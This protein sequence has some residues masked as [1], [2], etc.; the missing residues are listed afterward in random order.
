MPIVDLK[1]TVEAWRASLCPRIDLAS[2]ISRNPTAHK[3]KTTYRSIVL[4]ELVCWRVTDL[5]AQVDALLRQSHFLGAVVLLRSA[6]ETLAVLIYLNQKTEA[7]FADPKLFF[8]FGETTSRLML[9]SKNKTTNIDALNILTVL[10][11]CDEKFPGLTLMYGLLSESAHPN[12]DGVC[13]GYS[14]IDELNFV[15]NFSNR[16]EEKY[17]ELLQRGIDLCVMIFQ[18]EYNTVWP[19]NFAKLEKWIEENDDWLEANKS[20][21]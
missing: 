17:R 21:H 9:G 11:K 18:E 20:N 12:Y 10:A 8:H 2:L 1:R 5:L 6:F 7:I 3:W 16:W 13:S 19:D 14:S 15:T 4:R